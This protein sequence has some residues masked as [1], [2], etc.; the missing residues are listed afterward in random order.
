MLMLGRVVASATI[1]TVVVVILG[2][3]PA[4]AVRADP[5]VI[6]KIVSAVTV[7]ADMTVIFRIKTAVT[8][9]A[10]MTT[11]RL[12]RL[13]RKQNDSHNN[14]QADHVQQRAM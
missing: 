4:A 11:I 3:K 5:T 8:V 13:R 2:I 14:H 6:G 7:C 10:Q 12:C 1:R 9:T